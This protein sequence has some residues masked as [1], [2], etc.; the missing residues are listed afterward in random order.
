[1]TA[2]SGRVTAR[3]VARAA[4]VSQ[5]T[6]SYVINDNPNQKISEET[7]TRV[8]QAVRD[9]GY[10]PSAAARALRKGSSQVVLLILPD[11]RIG[12]AVSELIE[13]LEIELRAQDL[14][15]VTRRAAPGGPVTALWREVMP[16]ALVSLL[17]IDER[18]GEEIRSAG[19]FLAQ[20]LLAPRSDST[21]LSVPQQ[22]VGR[23][24]VEHLASRGHRRLGYARPDNPRVEQFLRL[25]LEGARMA[26]VELGL[27][28]P[29]VRT[30]PPDAAAAQAA[31]MAWQGSSVTAACAY[32]DETA[33][34]LLAGM[35]R[36]GLRAPSD[37]A[38]IG[39]DNIA[40]APFADPPLT[41][42]DQNLDIVAKHL[43]ELVAAGIAGLPLPRM[44]RSES[45]TLVVRESA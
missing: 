28:L 36:A 16:T 30:V 15:L 31:A 22:L 9:L 43:A 34:V 33:F 6:V 26:C 21:T 45:L 27:D 13:W 24:Q 17:P 19:I 2:T 4:G 1:M 39:V 5:A 10:T 38:V 40:L 7:R 44:P 42:I 23:L 8:L 32:N 29:D 3:D 11:V 37:I 18:E 35:R 12:H 41:T 20:S 14:G 25:R